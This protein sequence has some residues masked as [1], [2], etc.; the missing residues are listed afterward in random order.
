MRYILF[1]MFSSKQLTIKTENNLIKRVQLYNDSYAKSIL[2]ER[3]LGL[4]NWAY[5]KYSDGFHDTFYKSI[6]KNS[7]DDLIQEGKYG[8]I[9]SIDKFN[10]TRG[11]KFSTF[12]THYINGYIKKEFNHQRS[13]IYIPNSARSMY[14]KYDIGNMNDNIEKRLS[15]I[16]NI[17]YSTNNIQSLYS[18]VNIKSGSKELHEFIGDYDDDTFHQKR[19]LRKEIGE[20]LNNEE[21]LVILLRYGLYDGI[22][23]S[24]SDIG[25]LLNYSGE[26]I[27]GICWRAHIKLK[28]ELTIKELINYNNFF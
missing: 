22:M 1:L 11:I 15:Y 12:A 16:K 28:D 23:Y 19:L 26:K 24:F 8:L 9:K 5:N 18:P 21:E 2:V 20:I 13:I 7:K 27:R 10:T 17:V 14:K 6:I 25:E 4:V 3:N